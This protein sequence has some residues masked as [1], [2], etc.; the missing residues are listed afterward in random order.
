MS[1]R[2]VLL[3]AFPLDERMRNGQMEILAGGTYAPTLYNLGETLEAWATCVLDAVE[4]DRLIVVGASMGGSCA[5]EMARQAPGRIAAMVL[6]GTKASHHP[7]PDLRDSYIATLEDGG[8]SALLPEIRLQCFGPSPDPAVVDHVESMA[9]DQKTE[10]LIRAMSVFHGRRDL[11]EVVEGWTKPLIAICGDR[12]ELESVEK[13]TDLAAIAPNGRFHVMGGCGHY[14][15]L[16]RPVE[17]NA[18]LG[19]LVHSITKSGCD[20]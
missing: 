16:E 15:N 19:S 3:H 8:V 5:L 18:I 1:V 13:A 20:A 7:E 10:D 4:G 2:L 12:G 9:L 17:F 11:T 6:V 14:M